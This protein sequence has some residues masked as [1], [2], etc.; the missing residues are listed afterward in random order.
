MKKLNVIIFGMALIISFVVNGKEIIKYKN[1]GYYRVISLNEKQIDQLS[2]QKIDFLIK[3]Y[4]MLFYPL[5]FDLSRNLVGAELIKNYPD[6]LYLAFEKRYL[7]MNSKK[8]TNWV[9][10]L[11]TKK[12]GEREINTELYSVLNKIVTDFEVST[13]GRPLA[14]LEVSPKLDWRSV[15]VA[16]LFKMGLRPGFK[17]EATVVKDGSS[18]KNNR[19]PYN[20]N[21]II[22]I[23][24]FALGF[25][26][27][28]LKRAN[29]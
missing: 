18:L 12:N 29:K 15:V 1:F 5:Y 3:N 16:Y 10:T 8:K 4:L 7:D 9:K 13:W 28:N 17:E 6:D 20:K 27:S 24:A 19:F 14:K 23:I 11:F 26:F 25:L 2:N 21:L 22:F